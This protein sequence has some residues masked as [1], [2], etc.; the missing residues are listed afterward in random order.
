MESQ[1]QGTAHSQTNGRIGRLLCAAYRSHLDRR[2][3]HRAVAAENTAIALFGLETRMACGAVVKEHAS[4]R[5]HGFGSALAALRTSDDRLQD[6]LP[7][8]D[9]T[10]RL[11]RRA[12]HAGTHQRAVPDGRGQQAEQAAVK[13]ALR[14]RPIQRPRQSDEAGY[15]QHERPRAAV[16][17]NGERQAK[18]G[19]QRKAL[20][21]IKSEALGV[22]DEPEGRDDSREEERK[23]APGSYR[24]EQGANRADTIK[25]SQEAF[26]GYKDT[27]SA[28]FIPAGRRC[29]RLKHTCFARDSH[30]H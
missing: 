16:L 24:G 5:W 28:G 29:R 1:A 9:A 23:A 18:Q 7:G 19:E 13:H 27:L 8:R 2:A 25:K 14:E 17:P 20:K 22:G 26:R 30:P 4:I 15:A 6:G 11:V 21:G 3:R 10:T 12:A